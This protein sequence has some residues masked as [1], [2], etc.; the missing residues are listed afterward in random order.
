M[1][2]AH[3]TC[4]SALEK[5][6]ICYLRVGGREENILLKRH[7]MKISFMTLLCF[8]LLIPS[9]RK[10]MK[11]GNIPEFFFDAVIK[12]FRCKKYGFL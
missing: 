11:G 8:A 1:H 6:H 12:R 3:T 10:T 2:V 9:S 5:L 4:L 7:Q